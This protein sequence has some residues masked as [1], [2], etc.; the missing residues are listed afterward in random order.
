M[1]TG[2]AEGLSEVGGSS[3]DIRV[4]RRPGLDPGIERRGRETGEI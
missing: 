2:R 4:T 3:G 1:K